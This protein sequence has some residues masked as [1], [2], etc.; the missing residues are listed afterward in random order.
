MKKFTILFGLLC[1]FSL[2]AQNINLSDPLPD[3]H[4]IK[5]GVL[6]NGMTYYIYHTDVTKNVASYYIIQNVGSVLEDDDQQGLAHF[7][8]HM[9]FNGTENFTGKGILNTL[10]TQGLVFG[11]DINAYTDF[12]ETVYNVN[13]VPTTP[14]MI[15]TGLMI[16]KD[17]SNYLLLTD[18]EIDAERGVIREEWRTRQNG[19]MRIFQQSLSTTYNNS[20]YAERLPIGQMDI[21]DNFEY[22]ALRDF[23]HDWY[24]T[25]LQAIAIIGDIDVDAIEKK[26]KTMFSEI[27]AVENP[28]ERFVVQIDDNQEMLYHMAMDEEVS[29]ASI[30]FA[31]THPKHLRDQTIG[32]L[33]ESLLIEMTTSMLTDRL[34]EI[35]QKPIAPFLNAR[36]G[37]GELTRAKNQLFI[38]ISPKPEQQQEAF[39]SVME[40]VNR[41]MKFGFTQAELERTKK[42]YAN[43]YENQISREDDRSHGAIIN[44]IKS[45]YLDNETITD[46]AKEYEIIKELFAS[47]TTDDL[48]HTIKKLYTQKNRILSVTGVK[49][50]NN[51]TKK[52]AESILHSTEKDSS[53]TAY[54]DNFAGKTLMTGVNVKKG[55]IVSEKRV[56]DIDA[57]IFK[58][59]NGATVYYKFADKNK[60]DVQLIATSYGG[61]SLL[62]DSEL[63][64]SALLRDL[65]QLSG[66]G[67]YS[68]T[69]L[70][71][72]LA[73]KTAQTQVRISDLS[74][75]ITGNAVSKDVETLLQM[76]YLR[77]EKPRLDEDAY[78]VLQNNITSFLTRR[79]KDINAK[80]QDSV[81][82]TLYGNNNPKHIIFNQA[83]IDKVDFTIMENIYKSR[84]SN[85]ADFNFF[86]VGDVEKEVLKPLLEKY[87]ASISSTNI[88]ENWKDN[89]DSW[90]NP[91]IDKNIS[92]RMEDPKATVRI[93]YRNKVEYTLKNELLV[94]TLASIL[95]LRYTETL[96]EQ[97]GG[98]YG[99]SARASLSK[100]P[101][102][103]ANLQ[104]SFDCDPNKVEQLVVIVH[105]EIE[106]VAKGEIQQS[107]LDKTL[108][109]Y[110]KARKE[111]KDYNRY[112]MSWVTNYVLEGYDMNDPKNYEDIVNAITAEDIQNFTN[113]LLEDANTFEIIFEPLNQ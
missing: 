49:G 3:N 86:I 51:L 28:I 89:S 91:A 52:Q 2:M 38:S 77:F 104:I 88:K 63:P 34:S 109:N 42:Q 33:Q 50:E 106:K 23:Y 1:C 102:E 21:V 70:P 108:T 59:S 29:T 11:R 4:K 47:L 46:I 99:A 68:A 87:V 72:I 84:F 13:N 27:P 36:M 103:E 101:I 24:R 65:V 74:E 39:K 112:D 67:D 41:A 79:S 92:L 5:K 45:N 17:W 82:T 35:S 90:I 14:E 66:L 93:G 58:L 48:H 100:R 57:T 76:L 69:E 8:E 61:K 81:T 83:M 30:S 97:E 96:R 80:M 98:T 85:A 31:I 10:Q 107:D 75:M 32:D 94:G 64:S 55:K 53:L 12:D 43:Y 15:N 78:K 37:Y 44:T 60:D 19:S 62:T 110:I 71:K 95:Q 9:A 54:E 20:K 18:E 40:E 22:K 73:G 56:D 7:L 105:N 25:D 111:Q 6:S 26:I 16:L 113:E